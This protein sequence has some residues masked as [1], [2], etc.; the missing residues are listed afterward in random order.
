MV[1]IEPNSVVVIG[2]HTG[3]DD[4]DN[5]D[6]D[7]SAIDDGGTVEHNVRLT[8]GDSNYGADEPMLSS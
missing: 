2:D 8:N 3:N 5:N 6:D 1:S 7:V 4:D